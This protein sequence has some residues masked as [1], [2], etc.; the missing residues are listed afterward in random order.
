MK[1]EKRSKSKGDEQ[2]DNFVIECNIAAELIIRVQRN[3][4]HF[5]LYRIG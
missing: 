4:H 3:G 5:G 2:Y 1:H